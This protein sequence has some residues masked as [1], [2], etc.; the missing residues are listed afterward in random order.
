MNFVTPVHRFMSASCMYISAVLITYGYFLILHSDVGQMEPLLI[1][2]HETE[3]YH[4][5][6]T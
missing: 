5:V 3:K 4:K 2:A 1:P 6:H